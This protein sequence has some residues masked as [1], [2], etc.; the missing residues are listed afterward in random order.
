MIEIKRLMLSY[1]ESVLL[2]GITVNLNPGSFVA[3]LGNNGSGKSSLLRCVFGQE[4]NFEGEL[5]IGSEP[6]QTIGASDLARKL[7]IVLSGRV[8]APGMKVSEIMETAR[9]PSLGW[10]SKLDGNNKNIIRE[11]LEQM[12]IADLQN[13]YADQLSDGEYQQVMIA[14]CMAQTTDFMIM[15]E[16]SAFLDIL[17]KRN[18]FEL[19]RNQA[20]QGKGVLIA[21]HDVHEA[22]EFCTDFWVLD[23]GKLIEFKRDNKEL[24]ELLNR[25]FATSF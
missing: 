21:T 5:K 10:R 3:L 17:R 11:S 16:P 9:Y 12:N 8:A 25:I 22:L 1:D 4:Q 15:D 14:R 23:G 2:N 18:L 13:K 19:L 24:L 20:N 7:S 6:I